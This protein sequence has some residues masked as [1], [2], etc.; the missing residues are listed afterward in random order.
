[1]SYNYNSGYGKN[2]LNFKKL[3]LP[4]IAVF[5]MLTAM[6][7]FGQVSGYSF[8]QSTGTY[9]EITGGTQ[10]VTTTAG[11]TTYDSDGNS[12][13]LTSGSQFVFNTVTITSVNMT[14]DG[15]LWLNPGT[16]TTG[17]GTTGPLASTGTATGVISVLGMDLRSTSLA[18][19]VYERRW[20][21]T[22]TELVFQWKNASR[23]NQNTVERFSFQIR[24]TKASGII[25][26][27][28]GDI[29]N[30]ASS[31]TYQPI[32]GLRGSTNTDYKSRNLTTTVP[33]SSPSWDDTAAS[34]ANSQS[35]RFTSGSPA[36]F[37]AS[38]Q[39][40]TW[41]PPT[42]PTLTAS[43]LTA[44][45]NQCINTTTATPNSFTVSGSNLTGDIT[46]GA[47]TGY[48][49]SA[50]SGGTY[51]STLTLT[52]SSGYLSSV[53]VYVKFT[54]TATT[55][56]TGNI[57]VSGG[58]ATS[59][60][61]SASG[62]GVNT[63]PAISTNGTATA[64][65]T[66]ATISG[67]TISSLGCSSILPSGYGIE[68][69]TSS[70]FPNGTGTAV[71]GTGFSGSAGGT[72]SASISGLANS[73]TY[74]YRAYA[75]NSG[76]TTYYS[77]VSNFTTLTPGQVGAGTA[78]SGYVPMS[79]NWGYS[80]TQEIY[81]ASELTAVLDPGNT[82]ITK[83][84]FKS[85]T[86]VADQ[87]TYNN[88]V[89]YMGNTAKASFTGTADWV[90]TSAMTQVFSGTLPT[91]TAGNWVEI[92]LN[93][94]FLWNGTS[95]LVLAVDEN[96][97]G[98][99]NATWASTTASANRTLYYR[100]DTNNPN[101]ASP[102][103]GT[104]IT[105]LAQ[106]QIVATTPPDC[107]PPTG[108]TAA[109]SSPTAGSATF[110]APSVGSVP[111]GYEWE[112]RTSGNP[113]TG[114]AI[115]TGTPSA[116][117]TVTFATTLTP[118]TTYSFYIRSTCGGPQSTWSSAATFTTPK[119][120][121]TNYATAFAVGTA[122]TTTIP[123]TWAAA[124]GAVI[125]DGYLLKANSSA[126]F[127]DPVD[128]TDPGT[129]S[130]SMASLPASYKST[131]TSA[132]FT[133][134]TAG[135]M[136]YF[137][138]YSYTNT[139]TFINF[140][141]DGTVPSL[142]YATRPAVVASAALTPTSPTAA[143]ITWSL[144]GTFNAS[145]HNVLVFVK[146]S[147]SVTSGTPTNAPTTY[148]A[149]TTF[150][151]GTAYQ[152]DAAAYCVY[153]GDGTS[154]NITG[155]TQGITYYASIYVVMEAGNYDGTYTYS[156]ATNLNAA[157]PQVTPV[158]WTE[159]FATTSTPTGWSSGF[160]FG[161]PT[162]ITAT[163]NTVYK[164]LYS[165]VTTGEVTT[166]NVGLLGANDRLAFDYILS[167]FSSP[168]AVPASGSGNFVIAV[169]TNFGTSYTTLATVNNDGVAGW[170]RKTYSLSAYAG[171]YVKIRITGN[172]TSGDYYLAF[173][174]FAIEPTPACEA[175]IT[176]FAS[177]SIGINSATISWTAATVAPAEGYEYYYTSTSD[178]PNA[179]NPAASGN[180]AAG[181]TTATIS[182][183]LTSNTTYNWW[184]RSVC[185]VSDYSPWVSA[186]SF[187]TKCDPIASGFTQNFD[188]TATGTSGNP[189]V[190]ECWSFY[191]GGA[192]YGYVTATGAQSS[193]NNFYIY[194]NT[195]SAGNYIL[196]SPQTVDLGNGTYRVS[197]YAKAGG[198]GY[199]L[200]FGRMSNPDDP[201]TFT[202]LQTVSLTTTH[203]K[204]TFTLPATTD[205]Y[206]AFKHGQGGTIRSIYIDDVVYQPIPSCLE[207]VAPFA[208]SAVNV[209]GATLSWGASASSPSSGYDY[210]YTTSSTEDPNSTLPAASGSVAAGTLTA[211]ITGTLT[212]STQYYWW[213]RAHCAGADTS[214]WMAGGN[215]TTSKLEP[216]NYATN[217]AVG[218]ATTTTIP[219]TWTAATGAVLPDGYLLK[220]NTSATITDPVDATDPGAGSL[221]MA[222]VP[223]SY[224]S[225]G[226]S[227]TFTGGTAGTMYHFKN[228]SYTNSGT[229]INFKTD[230]SAPYVYF[231][232]KP[233]AVTASA[234]TSGTTGGTITW[235]LPG[236]YSAANH[237]V[238]VFVKSGSAVTTGTP[239]SAPTTYTDGTVFGTG[240]TYQ[241][242]AAAYCV[243]KGDGTTV[244]ISGL[245]ASTTYYV[246][247]LVVMDAS[248][249]N[250]TYSYSATATANF[251]TG[252]C[253]PA[254]TSVDG[255][256]ITNV[257]IGTINNTTT[258]ETNNYGNYSAMSFNAAQ[259]ATVPFSI[260]YATGYTYGT[261]I[262]VDW[263]DDFIFNDT[264]ELVYTGLSTDVNPTT[265][266]GS[267]TV[268]GTAIIGQHRLRIGGTDTDA[269][270]SSACYSGTYGTFEDYTINVQ[271]APAP[272]ITSFTPSTYCA[273]S[274]VITITGT[275]LAG[276]T[277]T[278]GGSAITPLTTNT[279]TS[280]TA[281]VPS[282]ISGVVKVTTSGGSFETTETFTVTTPPTLTLSAT[283]ASVCTGEA[284][285][286]ITVTA[287]QA[288]YTSFVWS[289]STGV[290][291]SP[292]AGYT[293]SPS[294]TTVYTLT[295]SNVSGCSRTWQVTATV[296]AK[297]STVNVTPTS[298]D[299][300][301]GQIQQLTASGGTTNNMVL[302]SEDFNGSATGWTQTNNSTG[303]DD[304][305]LAAWAI[306][307]SDTSF[308]SNDN[309]NFMMSDSDAQG[310]AGSTL[311]LLNSP[312]FS[313][314]NITA[315]TLTFYHYYRD[316]GDSTDNAR[317]QISTDGGG[318]WTLLGSAITSTQGSA[319]NFVL[320]S[321]DLSA[322]AGMTNLKIRF[323]YIAEW[324]YYWAIDNVTVKGTG[325]A[326]YTWQTSQ[327]GSLFTDAAATSAYTGDA[328]ATV[329]VKPV[330]NTTVTAIATNSAGCLNSTAVN[331]TVQDK[332]WT[333]TI[334]N[335]WNT[336]GNWCGG[337]VPTQY[338]NVVIPATS[339]QPEIS[340]GI[341]AHAN[342]LTIQTGGILT[343]KSGNSI[344][345]ENQV[346]LT[347]AA[348][349]DNPATPVVESGFVP[350]LVL[351]NNAHLVQVNNVA[352][353]GTGIA[354]VHRDSSPLLRQDYTMWSSPVAAQNLFQF[355]PATLANRFYTY[356]TGTDQFNAVPDLSASSGTTFNV[357]TGYL[358]RMPNGAYAADNTTLTG[359][360]NGS[361]AQYQA[362]THTMVF[363]GKFTGKTN[364]GNQT[365][366]TSTALNGYN[367]LGNPYPSPISIPAFFA[368][369]GTNT[370]GV[371]YLWRKT[372]SETVSS[373]YCTVNSNGDYNGNFQPGAS[374]PEG[375]L[376]T[377]Q[378]FIVK[379][380]A[381]SLIFNNGMRSTTTTHDASFFRMRNNPDVVEKH[382]I[383]LNLHRGTA[384][385]A[386]MLVGYM[387][388][389][390]M[391]V[392]MGTDALFINDVATGL[393]SYLDAKAYAIQGR[394]LPFNNQDVVPLQFKTN[395]A[396]SHTIS[397]DHVDGLFLLDQDI[398]LKDNL[399][400]VT[401]DL[402]ASPYTFTTETGTFNTRFEV[403]YTNEAL[404]TDTTVFDAN[405]MIIYKDG[406][407][408]HINTGTATIKTVQLFD[409]RGRLILEK[410]DVNAASTVISDLK[411]EEQMLIVKVTTTEG[412][413]ASK[414]VIY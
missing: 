10:L 329:Y 393:N 100:S 126:T 258:A 307:L 72:F 13:T 186:G 131:G 411:V 291:G 94:P 44:F 251:Y 272:A 58:G 369:N 339:T 15:A 150:G 191:D 51:T 319:T 99:A 6:S 362:G 385:V 269:G 238:L 376:Q 124:T 144:P 357:G 414:K 256:G 122:T 215:F 370:D 91:M 340:G 33:D 66:G 207:P 152:P 59:Q 187:R 257:T 203:T 16:T 151:S 132:T 285:N 17:N 196:I 117:G 230:G 192:G 377:G 410:N 161:V 378:G 181:V 259:N 395:V 368:A 64:T 386:Q 412:A 325:P 88:W 326:T 141:T 36:A 264:D 334:N 48:T 193:P 243:Y 355:S 46:I 383:W 375:I 3:L 242:D 231:A 61:V 246:M 167:N 90:A 206:F 247:A 68:Y 401:H 409:V 19:Q 1:M 336:A 30:I 292:S 22:G 398:Y 179:T 35:V 301:S 347:S 225:T 110:S 314:A 364:N 177:S 245:S 159:S 201:A 351:Q 346:S 240:S 367:L 221:S 308:Y 212:A 9:T 321:Y 222:T 359:T 14:S 31:T 127:T 182:S 295:A 289:P 57:V 390:T 129:G 254:P 71:T 283:T 294:A 400:G 413:K 226:T 403:V 239:T 2:V 202:S 204:Y 113:G 125:P 135:T 237:T 211:T 104:L 164:N 332:Q 341:T 281:T 4:I 288:D 394:S 358:I 290:S 210:Y 85:A 363:N 311:T 199:T 38:G 318:S 380:M 93:T 373:A 84:R 81:L 408:L 389:A 333:G 228:Y 391:G 219:L 41:S 55:A 217:F 26:M 198:S 407:N 65:L 188:S 278:I 189:T 173:D 134:G 271:L 34:T 250:G 244:T 249:Y 45:G 229:N 267:F 116:A 87:S 220:A 218:T 168:Y 405:S 322:Y 208:S 266:S 102:P 112:L 50:S 253:Q 236:T 282:G 300:C 42:N 317:V 194:N 374:D 172:W 312:T 25:K 296:N 310:E 37:P 379:S 342:T 360:I 384:P 62:T 234:T 27:V 213:V 335:D 255:S 387:S 146:A 155:L 324:G 143:T 224:K 139:G 209:S 396:G 392:D 163:T 275:N 328:R 404:G 53:P 331:I 270:P 309:T 293:F 107:N 136:Y 349:V 176:P 52:P 43:T 89:V 180:T 197:F 327:V 402:K 315:P 140:K 119:L 170:R 171:Q 160:N 142:N 227:A 183:G 166:I 138:N 86:V 381:S 54:P 147:S 399:A 103:S 276:A 137:K 406:G 287:G 12:I 273:T 83:I 178:N 20:M 8:A 123:V 337:Q 32:V 23:W 252:Y 298:A 200:L 7:S 306:Y 352:N 69:S 262:W 145:N 388:N 78:T 302:L 175:P 344:Q 111:S 174:N 133:G 232:T 261:K 353:T 330:V 323:R 76:G 95:N 96:V 11:A 5:L 39:T 105:D 190:P 115:E 284:S 195:D 165:S 101:P 205:D 121:P 397:I 49:Y 60:N 162:G 372:N 109:A 21:D 279:A 214:V 248:N 263:N 185:G 80:Y 24:I 371:M 79:P 338:D 320:A 114:S 120:E 277:L 82:Y 216:T 265:L 130:L 75:T 366:A 18:T 73:T 343:V 63:A 260:T 108:I 274:G 233:A 98:F 354:E 316:G 156:T 184:V 118:N 350:A 157:T 149:S 305:S 92:T 169:S 286:T 153:N 148:T 70:S 268:P 304:P 280:I 67:A 29:V 40:F 47:L 348:I 382:R 313:L 74:C 128:G 356:N 97:T 223:A 106:M 158:T 154:V 365:V 56:Y 299:L 345:V 241:G 28:Y 297:P 303:G 77:S 235:T 361:P